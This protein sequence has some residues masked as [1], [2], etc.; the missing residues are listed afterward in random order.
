[1]KLIAL[2]VFPVACFAQFE[3]TLRVR[4]ERQP[5]V[6]GV[7][8]A[9]NAARAAR[10]DE[11]LA[12][13]RLASD[14][15][16]AALQRELIRRQLVQHGAEANGTSLGPEW[17]KLPNGQFERRKAPASPQTKKGKTVYVADGDPLFHRANCKLLPKGC[18]PVSIRVASARHH[19]ACEECF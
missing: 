16:T 12:R 3:P 11:E 7:A 5:D 14:L 4:Y 9:L 13:E 19:V 8:S 6:L 15:E 2:L 1:M 10:V 18:I 17:V